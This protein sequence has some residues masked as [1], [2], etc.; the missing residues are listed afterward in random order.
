MENFEKHDRKCLHCL[1]QIVSRNVDVNVFPIEN[2][3]G[4]EE[5]GRENLLETIYSKTN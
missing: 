3:E 4:N 2:L 1:E 5:F